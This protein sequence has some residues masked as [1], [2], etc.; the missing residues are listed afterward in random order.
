[1]R[2][3]IAALPLVLL[4]ACHGDRPATASRPP[5]AAELMPVSTVIARDLGFAGG[6]DVT[7]KV[8][9]K[10]EKM[11]AKKI[12]MMADPYCETVYPQGVLSEEFVIGAAGEVQWAFVHVTNMETKS[13]APKE[14][15]TL[16]QEGCLFKPHVFG[17]IVGQTVTIK[18][19]DDTNHN[20]HVVPAANNEINFAQAKKGQA[21][22]KS[23]TAAE[24]AIKIKCDVHP[25]MSGW[26]H[27]MTHPY[28]SVTAADGTFKI[29][30]LP[31]GKW[32]IVAWHE[33][34]E[35]SKEVEVEVDGKGPKADVAFELNAKKA[36]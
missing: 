33:S 15:V 6:S 16:L 10:G 32:K 7:G 26:V 5:V 25:W 17:V 4:A 30:G 11:K 14:A 9:W 19:A 18:N 29:S 31:A 23:F 20:I 34:L 8:T 35:G 24:M 36:R 22:D 28:F 27:V 21:S 1:M 2:T 12:K 3:I 13:E